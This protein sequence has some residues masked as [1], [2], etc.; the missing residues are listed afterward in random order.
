MLAIVSNKNTCSIRAHGNADKD[1]VY[2]R[3]PLLW[4]QSEGITK[5]SRCS[6]DSRHSEMCAYLCLRY[7]LRL[8]VAFG[9][10]GGVGR[11]LPGCFRVLVAMGVGQVLQGA[12]VVQL[13]WIQVHLVAV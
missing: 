7:S 3:W 1:V 2:G 9:V 11:I 10:C 8:R 6:T 13:G 4:M 5:V 12:P